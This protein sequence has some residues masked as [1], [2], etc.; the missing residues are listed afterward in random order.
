M[1]RP[2]RLV[3]LLRGAPGPRRVATTACA[4]GRRAAP[5][6]PPRW[7]E[8]TG[9]A[10][11]IVCAP[12][13]LGSML[14]V[15]PRSRA[16]APTE[17]QVKAAF[18][19]NFGRFVTWPGQAFADSNAA[20]V[21]GILG[22]D[23]FGTDIDDMVRGKEIQ[24]RPVRIRR[25]QDLRELG[26]CHILFTTWSEPGALEQMFASLGKSPVLTVGESK[27][28]TAR[29]GVIR[30]YLEESMVRFEINV[31]AARRA[32]LEISSKMLRLAKIV[33]TE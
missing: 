3:R 11:L 7:G 8:A 21:L 4:A 6:R 10:A 23:P 27:D 19:V 17:H 28:F 13:V 22:E 33:G 12:L 16:E 29:G 24:G 26:T 18:L 25:L 20:F 30:F 5:G 31:N 1:G 2:M 15:P 32:E 9:R 14:L